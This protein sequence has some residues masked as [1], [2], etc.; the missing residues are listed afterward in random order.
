ML[1]TTLKNTLPTNISKKPI[2]IIN[3]QTTQNPYYTPTGGKTSSCQGMPVVRGKG[4]LV[5]LAGGGRRAGNR[6]ANN[7]GAIDPAQRPG[8]RQSQRQAAGGGTAPAK[9]P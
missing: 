9:Q 8:I 1:S 2:D 7:S 3:L 5:P 6:P 4:R